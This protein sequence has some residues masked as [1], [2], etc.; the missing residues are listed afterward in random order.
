MVSLVRQDLFRWFWD[1]DPLWIVVINLAAGPIR[2]YVIE[3]VR[4][5]TDPYRPPWGLSSL[6]WAVVDF[7][8][9][10]VFTFVFLIMR[11]YYHRVTVPESFATGWT[12]SLIGVFVGTSLS[13]G[14]ILMQEK[15][16]DYP[17]GH[18]INVDRIT[19]FVYFAI[20]STLLFGFL[21]APFYGQETQLWVTAF[22]VFFG[23]YGTC[24][25]LDAV[26]LNPAWRLVAH[27]FP[28]KTGY[29]L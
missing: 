10:F 20:V 25:V 4:S 22:V 11:E 13:A 5:R 1:L 12:F 24:M 21:R 3:L 8:D 16:G 18:K 17:P 29:I 27:H 2:F 19:H 6:R 9:T 15:G 23:G 14:F 26:N 28:D 7:G